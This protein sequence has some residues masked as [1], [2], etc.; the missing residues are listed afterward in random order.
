MTDFVLS[1]SFATE[2]VSVLYADNFD[3]A[4]EMDKR[5]LELFE[6]VA[7]RDMHARW[8]DNIK[9]GDVGK[10]TTSYAHA[11]THTP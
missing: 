1:P 2:P 3:L 9:M 7:V 8:F 11:D 4:D 10:H 5:F 6:D